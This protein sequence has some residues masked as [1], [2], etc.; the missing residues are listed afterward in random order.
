MYDLEI[1]RKNIGDIW[2]YKSIRNNLGK[3][4]S[5]RDIIL[6]CLTLNYSMKFCDFFGLRIL[7]LIFKK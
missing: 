1:V 4:N 7:E 6:K 5:F 2:V 3:V